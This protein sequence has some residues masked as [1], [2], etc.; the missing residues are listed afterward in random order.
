MP[1]PIKEIPSV[2]DFNRHCTSSFTANANK[3]LLSKVIQIQ[4]NIELINIIST[5]YML[6]YPSIQ[7]RIYPIFLNT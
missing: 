5:S 6:G 4:R 7:I 3:I 1:R 2:L